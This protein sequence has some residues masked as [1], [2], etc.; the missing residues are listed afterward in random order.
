[1]YVGMTAFRRVLRVLTNLVAAW[2]LL[3]ATCAAAQAA[4]VQTDLPCYLENRSVAVTGSGF[5][6]TFRHT[7]GIRR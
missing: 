6:P 7:V 1:M 5:A 2:I 4:T 3:A